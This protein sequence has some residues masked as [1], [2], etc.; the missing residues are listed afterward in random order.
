MSKV[1]GI[2]KILNKINNKSYIGSSSNIKSRWNVHLS[3]LNLQKH[4]SI[5]LQRA[6]NKYGEENFVFIIIEE[7]ENLIER[8]QFWLDYYKS[9]NPKFG[10]NICNKAFSTTGLKATE[11]CKQRAKEVHT[12][13]IE[14][15]ETRKKKSLA[16]MNNKNNLG[17]T[18][19]LETRNKIREK[20]KNRKHS[21]ETKQKMKIAKLGKESKNKISVLQYDL[22]DNLIQEWDSSTTASKTLKIQRT[23][24]IKCL[25]KERNNAG[26]YIWKYKGCV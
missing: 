7:C 1:S 3:K 9:Y 22:N 25:K 21:S 17:K 12:G 18:L 20:S 16:L 11:Y 19:S 10:Y 15:L 8:E 5:L 23:N 14:T 4:H 13:K 2:Y 26:N 24:I 6:Y